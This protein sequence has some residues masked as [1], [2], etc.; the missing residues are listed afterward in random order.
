M[1]TMRVMSVALMM[2]AAGAAAACDDGPTE[3][4]PNPNQIVFTANLSSAQEVPAVSNSEAGTTG[5]VTIT[6]NLTRGANNAI[7]AATANF[8][9]NLANLPSVGTTIILGHI[10]TGAAG[11]TGGPIVNLGISA[12]SPIPIGATSGSFTRNDIA[13][14]AATAQTIIDNP[15][16]HYFNVHS[17]LNPGGIARGQLV[18]Q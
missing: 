9:V 14:D 12:A 8:S 2:I 15:A 11:T 7:T 17:T 6:F 16:G 18:R 3:P 5:S 1:K 4:D 13:V 10:H